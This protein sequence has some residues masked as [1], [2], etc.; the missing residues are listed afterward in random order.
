MFE[1]PVDADTS[2]P[3]PISKPFTAPIDIIAFAKFASILSNTGSP[4]PTG[5]PVT[6]HSA[7]PPAEF[8]L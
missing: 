2:K 6:M 1:R 3:S 8:L 4:N 5:K 7:M